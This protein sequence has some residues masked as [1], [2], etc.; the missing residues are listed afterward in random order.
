[1]DKSLINEAIKALDLLDI[2]LYSTSVNRFENITDINHPEDMVQQIKISIN[3]EFLETDSSEHIKY[4]MINAK[5][6][7]GLRFITENKDD[8]VNI[9]SEIESCFIAKYE[10]KGDVSEDAIN[11]F[12]EY[13]VI[14]N[15]WPFWREHAFRMS[16]EAKLPHPLISLYREQPTMRD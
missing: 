8:E 7:I 13:N 14:H 15:V 5:V 3:A 9:L 6:N 2:Y 11:E 1:M 10:K 4:E 12:M 16:L